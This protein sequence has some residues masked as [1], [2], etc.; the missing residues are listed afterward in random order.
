MKTK[1]QQYRLA[2]LAAIAGM[3]LAMPAAAQ[4]AASAGAAATAV[5][6]AAQVAATQTAASAAA[7]LCNAPWF[8]SGS[9][10]QMEGDGALPMSIRMTLRDVGRSASGCRAQ[11]TVSSKSAMSA[12]MGP[13]VI[14]EQVHEVVI[15]RRTSNDQTS[16][17]SQHAVINA[18]AR[19]ARMYGEASFRGK[20]VFNYAGMDLREGSTLDGET[21]QSSVSLK[22]YP[23]GSDE[24]VST[25]RAL[26]ASI[27][28]GSR[29]VG[30][31]Q[32]IETVMGRKEC[33]PITY[34]KR[35]SLG[36]VLV[37]EEVVQVEPSVM[38]VTDWYC[39]SDA[40]VLRTEVRQ[41]G[42]V[43]RID[44]TALERDTQAP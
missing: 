20:G 6:A 18:R 16:I 44:V 11:L 3:L 17:E 34:E 9:H 5:S 21:F 41:D 24:V 43:Q 25:M 4:P 30:R 1:A 39:P 38:H 13:P 10:V 35:T 2:S 15:D 42:N 22:V 7:V 36:P 27:H 8:R 29:Q 14:M 26:H 32:V 33:L 40:F 28:I 19:Y 23:L 37:G 31:R 12:L